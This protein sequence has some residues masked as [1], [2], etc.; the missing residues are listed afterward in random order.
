MTILYEPSPMGIFHY[1]FQGT[2]TEE[3]ILQMLDK[4][5][6][7]NGMGHEH[8]CKILG[9]RH[10]DD[11]PFGHW[12]LLEVYMIDGKTIETTRTT[13]NDIYVNSINGHKYTAPA[14]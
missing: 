13:F 10:K 8:V 11:R 3:D 7:I 2:I 5:V 6:V 14:Q 1:M 12:F 4:I 9:L